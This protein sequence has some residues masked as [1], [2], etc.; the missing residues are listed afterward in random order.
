M[1]LKKNKNTQKQNIYLNPTPERNPPPPVPPLLVKCVSKLDG[2][3]CDCYISIGN[4]DD[5]YSLMYCLSVLIS[6][7]VWGSF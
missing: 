1:A 3:G 5:A 4:Y 2:G 6:W 7:P